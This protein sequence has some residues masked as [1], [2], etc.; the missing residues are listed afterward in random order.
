MKRIYRLTNTALLAGALFLGACSDKLDLVPTDALPADDIYTSGE[1]IEQALNGAY[2]SLSFGSMFGGDLQRDGELLGSNGA[3]VFSGTYNDPAEI[4][5]KEITTENVD[6]T[7]RWIR[8]YD[9]INI[10]NIVL[11][12]LELVNAARRDNVEGQAY[13]LRG[14]TYFELAR[15]WGQ[16]Y[17]AGNST[18]NLA[19][20]LILDPVYILEDVTYPERASVEAVYQQAI[21]DLKKAESLLD[22]V[23]G[24]YANSVA[25]AAVLSR[26]YLQMENWEEARDA[27]NRGLE[28]ANGRYSL[29]GSYGDAFNRTTNSAEDIFSIQVSTQDGTNNMQLYF[30]ATTFGGRGDIEVLAAHLSDYEA[31]DERLELFYVDP[32]IN[33]LRTGKWENQFANVTVIRLAEL[34]LTRAEANARL[35]TAIGATPAEDLNRIRSRVGLASID[36]PTVGQIVQERFLELALEGQRVH[37]LKRLKMEIDGFD[38]NAPELVFPIPQREINTNTNLRQNEG[39]F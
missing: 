34:Y 22:P 26:I 7:N 16:P 35:G 9:I 24:I 1:K 10:T 15:F 12:R 3:L 39:Y 18:T 8:S 37:D 31:D 17:S 28:L 13:F 19:V 4:W 6:V 2:N 27:A 32:A 23:N 36:N 33:K 5:R 20:P 30:A 38:Y 25:A 21:A 11:D 29:M 14:L